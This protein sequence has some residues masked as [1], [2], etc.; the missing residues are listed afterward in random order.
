M[1]R[2]I[3]TGTTLALTIAMTTGAMAFQHKAGRGSS[4]AGR[5][6]AGQMHNGG[7]TR[8]RGVESRRQPWN[9]Q[10]GYTDLGPLGVK[11]GD[12]APGAGYGSS[13]AAWSR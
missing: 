5:V 3:L 8:H 6:H 13:I 9:H 7:F 11:F 2:K 10:T 4:H 1:R 12:Y